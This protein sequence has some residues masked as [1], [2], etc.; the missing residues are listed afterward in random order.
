[1]GG[2]LQACILPLWKLRQEHFRQYWVLTPGLNSKQSQTKCRPHCNP[3][4]GPWD[5]GPWDPGPQRTWNTLLCSLIF[6]YFSSSGCKWML[7]RYLGA[8]AEAHAGDRLAS[9]FFHPWAS[10]SQ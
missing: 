7:S 9:L 5:L 10:N 4:H 6:W 1:M 2:V 8:G 3:P